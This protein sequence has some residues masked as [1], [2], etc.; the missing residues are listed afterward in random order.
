MENALALWKKSLSLSSQ[1]I[2]W[3]PILLENKNT[4]SNVIWPR[5]YDKFSI[6]RVF[7]GQIVLS[8][9]MT[10]SLYTVKS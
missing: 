1:E 6:S 8:V 9:K 2:I 10:F 4:L 7:D 5:M 3:T